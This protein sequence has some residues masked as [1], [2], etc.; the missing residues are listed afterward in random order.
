M[1]YHILTQAKRQDTINAI[2]HIPIPGSGV[3]EASVQWQ[4][5]IVLELGGADAIISVLPGISGAELTAMK[6]GEIYELQTSV[7]FST[8]GLTNTQRR[9]EIKAAFTAEAVDLVAEKQITL[10]F[11]GY[12]G[13]V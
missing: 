7:R 13:Y 1:D 9:S 11:I 8:L 2:F 5:A 3:N 6:A 4:N 10:S 12:G